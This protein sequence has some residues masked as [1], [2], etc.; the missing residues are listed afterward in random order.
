[1]SLLN[2]KPISIGRSERKLRD[3][4]F[5]VVA[6]DDTYAP[7]QYFEHLHLTRVKVVVL[8]TPVD[9]G[10]SAPVYVVNRLKEAV[11]KA[12]KEMQEGDEFWVLLDTDHHFRANNIAQ[13]DEALREARQ[14]GF[15]VAVSNPCFELWLLLH[16]KDIPPGQ[17]FAN[18]Q[19]VEQELRGILGD[20]NKTKVKL[21]QFPAEKVPDAMRRARELTTGQPDF[22]P[23]TTGTHVYLLMESVLRTPQA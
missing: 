16:H 17:A 9:S 18:A 13:T 11:K 12:R 8:E 7:T 20:Y 10:L 14:S 1:M 4:R 5:F 21:G 3:D 19:A 22:W 2:R 6:T 15:K 23:E